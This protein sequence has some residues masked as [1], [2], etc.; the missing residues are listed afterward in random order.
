M[1]R[2][3]KP[4]RAWQF[5][6]RTNLVEYLGPPQ[7]RSGADIEDKIPP[8]RYGEKWRTKVPFTG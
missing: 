2:K 7:E 1:N 5:N 3:L 4:L 8:L 6:P